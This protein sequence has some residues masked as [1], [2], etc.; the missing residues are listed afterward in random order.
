MILNLQ[1]YMMEIFNRFLEIVTDFRCPEFWFLCALV[2]FWLIQMSYYLFVFLRICGKKKPGEYVA[3][4]PVSVIICAKN[5]SENLKERLKFVLE[6]DYP[7]FEVIVV[8]DQS[9]DDTELVL[10]EYKQQYKNL[11]VTEISHDRN[12]RQGKKLALT[13][14][15]KAAKHEWLLLTDA[16]C[17]PVS[18]YWIRTMSQYFTDKNDFVLGYGGYEQQKGFVNKII[19]YDAGFIAMQYYTLAEAGMPYMGVGRN[20]AYRKSLFEKTR[21]FASHSRLMSGDDDIFVN[22]NAKKKRV[23]LSYNPDS[24]TSCI[25][26]NSFSDWCSQK[27]RHYTASERYKSWH[28]FV[29]GLE[30]FSRSAFYV[31]CVVLSFFPP[32]YI[33]T[34]GLFLIR[35]GVFISVIAGMSRKFKIK[36]IKAIALLL[37][38]ILPY[39][40]FVQYVLGKKRK[41]RL[42]WK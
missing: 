33:A 7:D 29:L 8:N 11:Y 13:I 19:R 37:D 10:D 28:K 42:K 9:T 26:K 31:L 34:A 17:M 14:G 35:Y 2:L 36:N 38:F 32:L 22:D 5:E 40:N 27:Q 6:Q 25:P 4:M 23:G 15:I 20:L 21:G 12:F 1:N 3:A 39:I 24:F 18:K 30:P 16:D 41:E